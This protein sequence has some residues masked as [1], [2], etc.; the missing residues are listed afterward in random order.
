M[1]QCVSDRPGNARYRGGPA[2]RALVPV[3]IVNNGKVWGGGG[4]AVGADFWGPQ[5]AGG[6]GGGGAGSDPGGRRRGRAL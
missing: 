6:S 3:T 5:T 2:L 4:G 1:V